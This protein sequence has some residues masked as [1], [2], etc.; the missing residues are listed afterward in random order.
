MPAWMDLNVNLS[1]LTIRFIGFSQW[2]K[3]EFWMPFGHTFSDPDYAMTFPSHDM[4]TYFML[5]FYSI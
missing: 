3:P 1:T 2:T 4:L 5:K